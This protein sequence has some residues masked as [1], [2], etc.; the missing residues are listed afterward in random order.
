MPKLV[1]Q[2]FSA[3]GRGDE[4]TKGSARGP[5]GPKKKVVDQGYSWSGTLGFIL[6]NPNHKAETIFLLVF[7]LLP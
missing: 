6:L 1:I 7:H 3:D 4:S 2:I 5:R